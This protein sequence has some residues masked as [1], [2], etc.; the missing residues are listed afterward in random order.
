MLRG[1]RL[2]EQVSGETPRGTQARVDQCLQLYD[3][4]NCHSLYV[5]QST[6]GEVV[7]YSAVHW[8]Y[9]LFL[10][11]PEGHVSELLVC[12]D[13]R[14]QG[15]GS[16]LLEAI[17]A[18]ALARGCS[19]LTLVNLKHRESYQRGF[20]AK[21]GWQERSEAA[22]FVY[23]LGQCDGPNMKEVECPAASSSI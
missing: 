3:S 6:M 13:D 2:F 21:R 14:G 11:G 17:K 15:I 12:L 5:A 7:G 20:Y 18:E 23:L 19:R 22:S 9:Y 8:L 10:T 4:D 1:L 16:R